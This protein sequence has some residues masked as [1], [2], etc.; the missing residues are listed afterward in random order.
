MAG[1]GRTNI[2]GYMDMVI[3]AFAFSAIFTILCSEYAGSTILSSSNA[4][5]IWKKKWLNIPP[6]R[7]A[8]AEEGQDLLK[9]EGKVLHADLRL[10]K[11]LWKEST[12][13]C[14]CFS[15]QGRYS[16]MLNISDHIIVDQIILH[17][18]HG[19]NREEGL[20]DNIPHSAQ[21]G[22]DTSQEYKWYPGMVP[23]DH[24]TWAGNMKCV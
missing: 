9:M 3:I 23:C 17:S 15:F 19:P 24:G 11:L 4:R 20:P 5:W 12:M 16:T 6:K 18:L 8:L 21:G 1:L 22:Q 7:N 10:P 2:Y 14:W 13:Y